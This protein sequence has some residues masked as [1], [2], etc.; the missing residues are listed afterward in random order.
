MSS[1]LLAC[2]LSG[3]PGNQCDPPRAILCPGVLAVAAVVEAQPVRTVARV[4][5]APV[6][7]V[8]ARRPV[9]SLI[10]RRPVRRLVRCR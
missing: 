5:V 10:A 8:L 9:R 6:R 3:C 4:A 1:I 2:V 7:R